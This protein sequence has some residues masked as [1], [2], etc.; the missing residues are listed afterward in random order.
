MAN[1]TFPPYIGTRLE[2]SPAMGAKEDLVRFRRAF[3]RGGWSRVPG[4][5]SWKN[6]EGREIADSLLEKAAGGDA[7]AR[8]LLERE[9]DTDL[10]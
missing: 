9:L 6:E 7:T 4:G 3:L 10:S 5:T 1:L 2:L 8:L